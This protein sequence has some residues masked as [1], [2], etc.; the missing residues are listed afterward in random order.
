MAVPV[1]V[2]H[3]EGPK[4]VLPEGAAVFFQPQF[5]FVVRVGIDGEA[6]GAEAAVLGVPAQTL[7][8]G[9]ALEA[10]GHALGGGGGED[11]GEAIPLPGELKGVGHAVHG[12]L[13]E[14]A[15][16]RPAFGVVG[17]SSMRALSM[18]T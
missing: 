1:A 16:A 3:A 8:A 15:L 2:V 14:R 6:A 13:V 12:D 17:L 18:G 11:R 4:A 5:Q 10:E 9:G 7:G